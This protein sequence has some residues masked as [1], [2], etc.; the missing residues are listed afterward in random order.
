MAKGRSESPGTAA[1]LAAYGALAAVL[2]RRRPLEEVLAGDPALARLSPRDRAFAQRLL[3]T[4]LR[5]LGQIDGL[6]DSLLPKGMRAGARRTRNLLRLGACQL[7]FLDTP[8][9]AAVG[10]AVELAESLGL[11]PYKGLV[12][13][14]LRRLAR[15]GKVLAQA[16]D[17]ARLNTP[18][19]LWRSWAQTYGEE[20]ARR[21]AE[22]HLAE[23]PLDLTVNGE[24]AGWAERLG[25]EALPTGTLR[26]RPRGPIAA[27]PGYADGPWWVQDAAAA[28]PARLLGDVRGRTVIDLCA[29]PG[30]KTAQLAA[31]GATV[32][33]VDRSPK[34]VRR[35]RDNLA[36]LR[37][38]AA[39]VTADAARWR[40]EAPADAVLLDAPC[41]ATGTV[42]RHPDVPR[43]RVADDIAALARAQDRL[44]WSALEMVKPGGL[45]VYAAC[46]LEREEGEARIANL[47]AGGAPA[48]RV[49][50]AAAEVGGLAELLTPEGDLRTLPC[51]L[52][53]KGGLDGFY[54]ARLRRL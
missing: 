41:S 7:V 30:G 49:P 37:L 50:V 20:T 18:D 2:G 16:Q 9:H 31:A 21:I 13:A 34:R 43:L 6:V 14:L 38:A 32:V 39:V 3:L 36:R 15:E 12:N 19:W 44:L 10:T 35:L 53:E 42:R 52:A 47:L 51:H 5:R 28:L 1:R 4:T 46:S 22:A 48:Q 29:A 11:A 17:A 40:P 27:L 45:L 25:A 8:A 24:A 26:F 23:P 33:A 54:A